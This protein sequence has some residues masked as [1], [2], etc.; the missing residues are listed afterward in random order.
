MRTID[1]T[2]QAILDQDLE[3]EVVRVIEVFWSRDTSQSGE[4]YADKEV[5]GEQ[6]SA[7]ILNASEIDAAVQVTSGGQARSVN[8]LL[9]DS[10]G[11]LKAR[12]DSNPMHKTPVRVWLWVKGTDFATKK[13]PIFL[14]QI[15]SPVVWSDGARTLSL[16]VVNRIEDVR[17]GFT[18]EEGEFQAL[19]EDL[20]GK[21]WPL[22][23]GTCINVPATKAVPAITGKLAGG[24]GV[25]DFTLR[26]RLALAEA[27]T[28]PQTPIGF[29]C[30]TRGGGIAYSAHCSIAYETDQNCL[31]SRCVEIEKLKV[32]IEEQ[33][34]YE[35]DEVRIFG[36]TQFP[37]GREITVN[38][39]GAIFKG[40][41][42]GTPQVP[43][44][45]FSIRSRQHPKYDP[46]TGGIVTD[47]IENQI[48]SDC[49]SSAD[50]QDS[51]FQDSAFGALWTGYRNSRISWENYRAAKA[52]GFFWADGGSDVF[53]EE[54]R[55][56]IYIANILP[57]TIKRVSAYR[58]L[59]GN[60]FLLTV[61]DDLY[62]VRQTDY[63]GYQVMEIVFQRPLSSEGEETGGGWSDDIYVSLIS[64]VGPNTVDILEWI[65]NTYTDYAIDS[66]SFNSVKTK[67]EAYP[68]DFPLL[69]RPGLLEILQ[70]LARLNRC[71]IWQRDDTFFIKYLS[72]EPTAVDELTYNDTVRNESNENSLSLELTKTEDLIT[73]STATWQR[74]YALSEPNKLILRANVKRYGS[75]DAEEDYFVFNHQQLVKKTQTFWLIRSANTWKLMNF[76]TTL[77]FIALEPFDAVT[78][79]MPEV[80]NAPFL[81][82]IQR[83]TIDVERRR[84]KF[85]VWAPVREGEMTPYN[86]AWPAQI[87]ENA[88]FP[89]VEA[90]NNGEAGSGTEPNFSTIAPP[91][92]PLRVDNGNV[93][94]GFNLGCNGLGVTSLAPGECRQDH[95]DSRPSDRDDVKPTTEIPDDGNEAV[96]GGSS[97]ISNGAGTGPFSFQQDI[98]DQATKTEGDAGRG[99]EVG[100][101]GGSNSDTSQ[102]TE[103][104]IDRDF[105]DD[106]PDPDDVDAPCKITVTVSG[107]LTQSQA[108]AGA[109]EGVCIPIGPSWVDIYVYDQ[110]AAAESLCQDLNSRSGCSVPPCGMCVVDCTISGECPEGTEGEGNLLGFRGGND[111]YNF[112]TGET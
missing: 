33:S 23:F 39:R 37:Q 8:I 73:E 90:Q 89:T 72:E 111:G 9:D 100:E 36:G 95:G 62:E 24:V 42:K 104:P 80:A 44:D 51:N 6:V 71:A 58:T 59:N 70:K 98:K 69:T 88:I 19:P 21:P 27:I 46:S 31:Q 103:E 87:S 63:N 49:P 52:A 18:A 32:Q 94:S 47:P 64:T 2:V 16:S 66:T 68:M 82:L 84:M 13:F 11:E 77:K 20:I 10:D 79:H 92:H 43:T 86:F 60:R 110:Q 54:A 101:S 99:R 41:F 50:S 67:L 17:I 35:Y 65:I 75:H 61:P 105:L 22:C 56:I 78:I 34:A 30:F 14:G 7:R 97:P 81:G 48:L 96:S 4:F 85:V 108:G 3:T 55:E 102:P 57:S 25:A 38:I 15:N 40:T 53:L 28:C 91:G 109:N 106:L 29:K 5:D 1:S 76:E 26:P 12:F 74:D 112:M 93:Y 45:I 83:A 107:F